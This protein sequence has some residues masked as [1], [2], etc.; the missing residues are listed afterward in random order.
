MA[1][2]KGIRYLRADTHG[3]NKAVQHVLKEKGFRYRGNV[4]V[5][6]EPGHDTARQAFEKIIK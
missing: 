2:A 5:L 1:K 3:K 6:C 4:T